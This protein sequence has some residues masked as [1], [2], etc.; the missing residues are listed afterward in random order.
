M[1][2]EALELLSFGP[3]TIITLSNLKAL[4]PKALIYT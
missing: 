4:I 1:Q 3:M 2:R